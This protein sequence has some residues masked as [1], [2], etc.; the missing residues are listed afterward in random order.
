MKTK[1]E[2]AIDYIS[3]LPKCDIC[4][5][6][7]AYRPIIDKDTGKTKI[8][9]TACHMKMTF[10]NGFVKYAS[11]EEPRKEEKDVSKDT[12]GQNT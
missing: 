6:N 1:H 4:G 12:G 2:Q 11:V 9:C 5:G 8:I 7:F 10:A 3:S